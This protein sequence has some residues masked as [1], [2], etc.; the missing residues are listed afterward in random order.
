MKQIFRHGNQPGFHGVI[1]LPVLGIYTPNDDIVEAVSIHF[2]R[3][4]FWYSLKP[5]GV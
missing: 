4:H 1:K 3:H 5:S 2:L